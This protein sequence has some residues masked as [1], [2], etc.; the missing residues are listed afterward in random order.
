MRAEHHRLI[1]TVI[2]W[3]VVFKLACMVLDALPI[4]IGVVLLVKLAERI[5]H[6]LS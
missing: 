3:V 2:W 4:V 1:A 6:W 5:V